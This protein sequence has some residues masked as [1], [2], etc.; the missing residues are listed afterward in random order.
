MIAMV[1]MERSTFADPPQRFEAGTPNV[2][3]AA[4]L[5]AA[6]TCFTLI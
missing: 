3:Q 5:A 4:G 6:V 2:A 1:T